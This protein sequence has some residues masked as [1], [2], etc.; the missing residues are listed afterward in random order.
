MHVHDYSTGRSFAAPEPAKMKSSSLIA[1]L[2]VGAV[3]A[4]APAI[5]KTSLTKGKQVC[6]AAINA[7]T[8]APKSVRTDGDATKSSDATITYKIKVKN[9]DDSTAILTCKINRATD[10]PTIAPAAE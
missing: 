9:A 6:E 2:L 5:A 1:L 4:A 3:A 10:M 8:P 7:Q